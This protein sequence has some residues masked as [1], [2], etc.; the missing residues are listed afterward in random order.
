[1]LKRVSNGLDEVFLSD[2]RHPSNL[3]SLGAG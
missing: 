2:R 3:A 1:V